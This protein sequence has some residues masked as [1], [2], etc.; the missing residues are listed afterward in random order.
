MIEALADLAL[1]IH[2]LNHNGYDIE[3]F[4]AQSTPATVLK[5]HED[6]GKRTVVISAL[7]S[8]SR[9]GQIDRGASND[10]FVRGCD[11]LREACEELRF[12][13]TRPSI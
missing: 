4:D 1:C 10:P 12:Q 2:E 13:L 9:F 3:E 5:A 6:D 8:G 11:T 7:E